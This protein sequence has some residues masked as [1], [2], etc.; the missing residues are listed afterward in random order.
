[1]RRHVLGSRHVFRQHAAAAAA[2]LGFFLADDAGQPLLE[3]AQR[4]MQR[5]QRAAESEAI[6][7]QLRHRQ[8][9]SFSPTIAAT[10][11]RV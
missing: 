5:H 10:S 1:M 8:P 3:E 6:L 4:V 11:N 9:N 2:E 7:A